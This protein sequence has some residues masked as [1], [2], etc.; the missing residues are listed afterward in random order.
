MPPLR[1]DQF[2]SERPAC[3]L[4]PDC[5]GTPAYEVR[6]SQPGPGWYGGRYCRRH[7]WAVGI[8]ALLLGSRVTLEPLG[9]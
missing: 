2:L 3:A 6:C 7:S 9:A 1:D 5:Q 8:E 4:W